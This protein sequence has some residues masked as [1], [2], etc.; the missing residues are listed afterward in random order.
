MGAR[1]PC[2]SRTTS[3]RPPFMN[4]TATSSWVASTTSPRARASCGTA[5]GST[6][7]PTRTERS[8][9]HLRA[10]A[11]SRR[12]TRCLR[13]LR[14]ASSPA[15]LREPDAGLTVV[16]MLSGYGVIVPAHGHV[17]AA[18]R[19]DQPRVLLPRRRR[20]RGCGGDDPDRRRA[21]AFARG[22]ASTRGAWEGVWWIDAV[23][24]GGYGPCRG[25]CRRRWP[26]KKIKHLSVDERKARGKS[27]RERVPPS[28]HSGWKPAADRPDP[29]GVA[30][31]AERHA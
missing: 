9:L 26:V 11:V 21:R 20:H 16:A 12:A 13:P 8:E 22:D 18:L 25:S 31:G 6:D 15:P 28:G 30:R 7:A 3:R 10:H 24:G 29:V 1:R 4:A 14:P 5:N 27:A 17:C 2:T 23:D 19:H